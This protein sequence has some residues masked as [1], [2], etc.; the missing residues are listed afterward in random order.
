MVVKSPYEVLLFFRHHLAINQQQFLGQVLPLLLPQV[1]DLG[2]WLSLLN[3]SGLLSKWYGP[4][5]F[6]GQQQATCSWISC[7]HINFLASGHYLLCIWLYT[8]L[9][10][11]WNQGC[12]ATCC[13]CTQDLPG[14]SWTS[15]YGLNCSFGPFEPYVVLYLALGLMYLLPTEWL[16]RKIFLVPITK[17][18]IPWWYSLDNLFYVWKKECKRTRLREYDHLIL[19]KLMKNL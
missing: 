12:V 16:L 1:P 10:Q 8:V 19:M 3:D 7:C 9:V 4:C 14:C 2:C 15:F 5:C 17:Q 18:K 11:R 6:L 13:V